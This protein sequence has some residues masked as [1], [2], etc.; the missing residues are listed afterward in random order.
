[1]LKRKIDKYLLDWKKNVERNPLIIYGARQIG[2][3][4]SIRNFSKT[5]KNYIEINFISN[6]EY[7]DAFQTFD[8][9]KIISRLSFINPHFVFEPHNTLILFDEIQEFMDATTALKFFKLDGRYDVICTGSELGVNITPISSVAVGFKD[10]YIMY[11]LDFEEFLWAN[12]YSEAMIEQLLTNMIN[13]SPLDIAIYNRLLELY[14]DY[15]VVG[16]YP[17]IIATYIENGDNFSNILNLQKK[18]YKDY[19]DDIAKY[20]QGIDVL[21]A[22]RVFTSITSQLSKDNHKFQFTKLGH[23][24]RF[25]EYYGV[26]DYLKSAGVTLIANNVNLQLPLKGNEEIENFRMYYS[27]TSLLIASLDEQTQNDFRTKKN[28]YIYNGALYESVIA[29]ELNK[30]GYDLYFYRSKDATT[31]LDFLIRYQDEILPLEV[32][33]KNGRT[34]S[35]NQVIEQNALIN[36]GIKLV[37]ANIGK[38]NNII[39]FPY[40][41]TFLLRRYI[42]MR[43]NLKVNISNKD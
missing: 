17:K 23:G 42:S 30:Q 10:E 13:Y 26:A 43:T 35:L 36:N 34:K 3:T 14:N 9:N 6:P 28:F 8:I 7:K 21:K 32:K 39:T 18:L 41:L 29:S 5:Y 12:G 40:F 15:I 27:D 37:N 4:T 25:N 31:E 33:A 11:A 38:Q 1:M 22:K 24:A 19:L 2:K 20:L 16:G